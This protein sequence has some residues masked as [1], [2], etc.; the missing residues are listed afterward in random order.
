MNCTK[1]FEETKPIY[2]PNNTVKKFIRR[3]RP[4]LL[5]NTVPNAGY[6]QSERENQNVFHCY[7]A[8]Y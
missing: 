5:P 3:A 4:F 8:F 2:N 6:C 7:S 1:S